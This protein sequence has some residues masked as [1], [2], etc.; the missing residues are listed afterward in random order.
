MVDLELV[1]TLDEQIRVK[2]LVI[3]Y[4]GLYSNNYMQLHKDLQNLQEQL[5]NEWMK[6]YDPNINGFETL[7]KYMIGKGA[8]E[9]HLSDPPYNA[10]YTYFLANWL[11]D[12]LYTNS[13]IVAFNSLPS[14]MKDILIKHGIKNVTIELKKEKEYRPTA[15]KVGVDRYEAKIIFH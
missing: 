10:K 13:L 7:V 14:D 6:L 8:R 12:Q 2:N 5:G 15:R 3:S 4:T 11:Y 9:Y 1:S